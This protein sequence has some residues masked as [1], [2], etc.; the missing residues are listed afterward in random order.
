MKWENIK[1]QKHDYFNLLMWVKKCNII[2]QM[3]LSVS[4]NMTIKAV[5]GMS[6]T[7]VQILKKW[8]TS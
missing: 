7:K 2:Y 6:A 5:L 8:V 4:T 1:I 3:C